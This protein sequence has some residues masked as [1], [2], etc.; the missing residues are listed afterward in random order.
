M[1]STR[2]SSGELLIL[3]SATLWGIFPIITVLS[4]NGLSP[5]I[6]LSFSSL[7]AGFFFAGVVTVKKNWHEVV[8]RAAFK[9]IFFATLFIGILYYLFIFIGLQFTS[10]GNVSIVSMTE[11]FFSFLF[12]HVLRKEHLPRTQIIGAS[13]MIAGAIVILAP[14]MH[15]FQIGDLLILAAAAVAPFGNFFVQR[16]RRQV[17]SETIMMIR[18]FLSAGVIFMISLLIKTPMSVAAVQ[19]SFWFVLING[20]LLLGLSKIFWIEGIHRIAVPTA[21]ALGSI[22]PLV[23]LFAAW[24]ILHQSPTLWQ[25]LSLIPICAG[26]YFISRKK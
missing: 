25:M 22:V 11:V 15:S 3:A 24:I 9:N 13:L 18:S 21:N 23:T 4:Y 26:V 7:L 8:N 6:S 2:K 20:L 14:N 10:P 19:E 5:L 12:F 1:Q 17:S 16:A